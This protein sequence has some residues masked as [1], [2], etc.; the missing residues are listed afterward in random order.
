MKKKA[1]NQLLNQLSFGVFSDQVLL[2]VYSNF[3]KEL[4]VLKNLGFQ[5]IY[6]LYELLSVLS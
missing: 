2:R 6:E 5:A 3:P 1:R 4:I